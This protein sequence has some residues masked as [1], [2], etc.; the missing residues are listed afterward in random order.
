MT[1]GNIAFLAIA[2]LGFGSFL[3]GL[4]YASIRAPGARAKR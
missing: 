4:V 3:A 1:D 2:A